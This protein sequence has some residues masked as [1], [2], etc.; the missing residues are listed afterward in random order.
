MELLQVLLYVVIMATALPAGWLLA[1]LCHD[2]LVDGKKW[3]Y[4]IFYGLIA[5]LIASLLFYRKLSAILS[6]AYMMIITIISLWKANDKK[7]VNRKF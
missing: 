7:F 5:L 1:W 6:L 3:F 2:E 4:I